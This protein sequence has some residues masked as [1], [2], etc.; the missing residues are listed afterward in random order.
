MFIQRI[1]FSYKCDDYVAGDTIDR[2]IFKMRNSLQYHN[3]LRCDD[4]MSSVCVT[5]D[6]NR[7]ANN[8]FEDGTEDEETEIRDSKDVKTR[9]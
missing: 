9:Y 7:R 3:S 1:S 8:S 2:K 6:I 5:K 4:K